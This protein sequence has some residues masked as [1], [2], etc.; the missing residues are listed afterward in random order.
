[1]STN[2]LVPP[3]VK[4]PSDVNKAKKQQEANLLRKVQVQEEVEFALD[5]EETQFVDF[6]V[7]L[8]LC[9]NK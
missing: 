6:V 7:D 4:K 5:K 3:N 8:G 1:M 2:L 9:K